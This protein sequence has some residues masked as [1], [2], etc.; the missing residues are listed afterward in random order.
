MDESKATDVLA[1]GDLT[2]PQLPQEWIKVDEEHFP[3]ADD[4]CLIWGRDR[5]YVEGLAWDETPWETPTIRVVRGWWVIEHSD[6]LTGS[7]E[8]QAQARF[9]EFKGAPFTEQALYYAVIEEAEL[10]G[11]ERGAVSFREM[12]NE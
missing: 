3:N 10:Q 1:E 9:F 5:Q 12:S 2:P 8:R 7:A 11:W 6:T 4:T